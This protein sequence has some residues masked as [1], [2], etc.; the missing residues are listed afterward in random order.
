[1]T[2][3]ATPKQTEAIA[4][5]AAPD[6]SVPVMLQTQAARFAERTLSFH[7]LRTNL[8]RGSIAS[9]QGETNSVW[10]WPAPALTWTV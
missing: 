8:F 10:P 5:F 1:M 3:S 6:R 4:R 9:C 7:P 2:P